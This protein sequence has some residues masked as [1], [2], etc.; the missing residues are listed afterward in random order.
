MKVEV[1]EFFAL[2]YPTLEGGFTAEVDDLAAFLEELRG[3]YAFVSEPYMM[4]GVPCVKA[5]ENLESGA[6][7]E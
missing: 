3:E 4:G 6:G 2:D 1:G 7:G 5:Y